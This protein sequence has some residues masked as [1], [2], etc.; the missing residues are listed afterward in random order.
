MA[1]QTNT[2]TPAAPNAEEVEYEYVE[3]PE[4]DAQQYEETAEYEYVEAP[5]DDIQYEYVEVPEGDAQQYEETAEYEYVEAPAAE[6]PA[7]EENVEYE[8]VE[9]PA[10]ETPATEENVE[11]EYVEAPAAEAPAAEENVEYEYV[12]APA[13]E[14]PATEE[15]VEYEYVEAPAAEAPAAE[16]NVEYEYVEAP[17]A[18]TPAA[19]ENVEY[20]Y[21]EAPAAE[22]SATEENVEYE[23]VEAPATTDETP[24][25]PEPELPPEEDELPPPAGMPEEVAPVADEPVLPPEEE[26]PEP[27]AAQSEPIAETVAEPE[28]A[29]EPADENLPAT[30]DELESIAEQASAPIETPQPT[31]DAPAVSAEELET[32]EPEPVENTAEIDALADQTIAETAAHE[33]E[34]AQNTTEE[35]QE[36]QDPR[37]ADDALPATGA[38]SFDGA[39]TASFTGAAESDTVVLTNA[40][41]AFDDLSRWYL[42]ISEFS[43]TPL[44]DQNGAEIPLS[45]D[46]FCQGA[47]I[48]A[49]GSAVPFVNETGLTVPSDNTNLA[50]CGTKVLPM[51]GQ[52]GATIELED[53]A[54]MLI[55]PNGVMLMFSH[56]NKLVVPDVPPVAAQPRTAAPMN[57]PVA[58]ALPRLDEPAVDAFVFT[59]DDGEKQTDEPAILVKTG[60]TLYGWNVTFA[61]GLTMSLADVRTFQSKHGVLPEPDGTIGY[62]QARLTFKNAQSIRVYE[63]PSYCGYGKRPE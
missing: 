44:A 3:V 39:L 9:A 8:Y 21:V 51:A 50:L 4:G 52:E 47:F 40:A 12:E 57:A 45:D 58:Y 1:E 35:T 27:V 36:E 16:E 42:L 19:E 53:S 23:Y 24:A 18:E 34:T 60:Y 17:A 29:P 22:A 46:I 6:A 5:A 41:H 55:G 54:G 28:H 38:F 32:V 43:V 20:E 31:T 13:A 33:S 25:L 2:A 15:N 10:A 49:D 61:S 7:A 59:A 62:K 30:A 56:L 37:D 26:I 14:T 63:K 48:N 11:Y